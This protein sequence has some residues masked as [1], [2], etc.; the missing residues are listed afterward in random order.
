VI[1]KAAGAKWKSMSPEEKL[2][3]ENM[4]TASKAE[5]A[6]LKTLTPAER[7]MVAAAA[8]MQQPDGS[9]LGG[10]DPN[11]LLAAQAHHGFANQV[12]M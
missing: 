2:P 1:G 10:T 5:Y 12:I 7:V 6:R 11:A 3:Y 9:Q 8:R 4:S